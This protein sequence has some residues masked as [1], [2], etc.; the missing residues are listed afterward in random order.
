MPTRPGLSI[1]GPGKGRRQEARALQR[2]ERALAQGREHPRRYGERLGQGN[3]ERMKGP[4]IWLHSHTENDALELLALI[5]RLR[6]ERVELNF[7]LTTTDFDP[8]TPLAGQMPERCIHQY[9]PYEEGPGLGNML[10]HWRPDICIWS[11][12]DLNSAVIEALGAREIPAFWV[13]A[14]MPDDK[15]HK[16]RWFPGAARKL[17]GHFSRILVVDGRSVRNLRRLG[18]VS[19]QMEVLGRL[20]VGAPPLEC[21][22]SERERLA[23]LLMTRP[24]W[25][26]A[27]ATQAEEAMIIGAHRH[28]SRRAHR[29]L[30]ILNPALAAHGGELAARLEQEGWV[31]A[32]RSKDQEPTEDT[33]IFV[34]DREDE[35][36]LL[37]RLAPITYIGQTMAGSQSNPVDPFQAAALGSAVLHGPQTGVFSPRFA[38][39]RNAG[40]AREICSEK[41]LA[42]ELEYLL[43]PDKVAEMAQ[44][45]W[46]VSTKGAEVTDRVCELVHDMLDARGI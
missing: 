34:A 13:N 1:L 8:D 18:V 31:V 6:L 9:L 32:L 7:L 27:Q 17:L 12:P 15:R 45:A 14:T 23:G 35:L 33:Q 30:L 37:F 43:A 4:L 40:A 2:L 10:D 39:L 41:E 11:A 29:Q 42:M 22:E 21:V 20:M 5:D 3:A 19:E 28:I 36:G 26:A 44:A 16:L 38:R 24:V 46:D 25:M